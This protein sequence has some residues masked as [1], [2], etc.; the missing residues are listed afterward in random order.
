[1]VQEP[2]QQP[3]T[4]YLRAWLAS[5]DAQRDS[6]LLRKIYIDI[7]DGSLYAGVL[8]SQIMYWHGANAETGKPRLTIYRD[9]HY[10][11]AKRYNEW[12]QECRINEFTA[13]VEIGKMVKRGLLIKAL[14][15]FGGLPTVHVRINPDEFER[16]VEFIRQGVSNGIDILYLTG[17]LRDTQPLTETPFIE[18][19]ID[20]I[21]RES[22]QKPPAP[23]KGKGRKND[24][25]EPAEGVLDAFCVLLYDDLDGWKANAWRIQNLYNDL[26]SKFSP[27]TL[28]HVRAAYAWWFIE[29]FRGRDKDSN[30]TPAQLIEKWSI[31]I[32]YDYKKNKGRL[33]HGRK[34]NELLGQ[35]GSGGGWGF[36]SAEP[37]K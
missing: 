36:K 27:P 37:K 10:W 9:G 15:K 34:T 29:D 21:Q 25:P 6:V 3:K 20:P 33:K 5:E 28:E 1:M 22:G 26:A 32:K 18:P 16:R 14:Y 24:I 30:P 4:S 11:L 19:F 8:F 2:T 31:A 35:Q 23:K 12:L 13:K 7:N 17:S